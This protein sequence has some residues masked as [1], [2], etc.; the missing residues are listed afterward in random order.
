MQN[1]FKHGF[2]RTVAM[3]LVLLMLFTLLPVSA[4]AD[5]SETEPVIE[6]T[7]EAVS[8]QSEDAAPDVPESTAV[9]TVQEEEVVSEEAD[10]EADVP[11]ASEEAETDVQSVETEAADDPAP[12]DSEAA[13][14]EPAEDQ[15][16]TDLEEIEE[17][18]EIEIQPTSKKEAS[19]LWPNAEVF[20]YTLPGSRATVHI[21]RDSFLDVYFKQGY[22][23]GNFP[24][25]ATAYLTG[26]PLSPVGGQWAYCIDYATPAVAGN[27]NSVS[28]EDVALWK[29]K[30]AA[31]KL[32]VLL[33]VS[34]GADTNGGYLDW[35]ATQVVVWEYMAGRTS[36]S[37]NYSMG[38]SFYSDGNYSNP[39][40]DIL[41]KRTALLNK[42]KQHE[43]NIKL[44]GATTSGTTQTVTLSFNGVGNNYAQEIT[45]Q[46][47]VVGNGDWKLDVPEGVHAEISNGKIIVYPTAVFTGEKTITV[48][49]KVSGNAYAFAANQWLITGHPKNP[50]EFKIK[51]TVNPGKSFTLIKKSADLSAAMQACI[52]GNPLYTMKGAQYGVYTDSACNNLV[53]TLTTDANGKVT[54][55]KVWPVGT[56][57]YVK[58]I[59]APSGYLLDPQIHTL[60]IKDGENKLEVRDQPTFDPARIQIL[61]TGTTG[62]PIK[63][64]VFEVKFY[65]QN[66]VDENR[67]L[68]TWYFKSDENGVVS[69][70]ETNLMSEYNGVQSDALYKPNGTDEW[71]PLGCVVVKEVKAADGYILPTG[72]DGQIFLFVRQGGQKEPVNGAEAI[73]YWGTGSADPITEGN[74]YGIFRFEHGELT[75][76]NGEDMS[77]G[78]NA[79]NP[80]NDSHVCA[81]V[82]NAV[83]VDTVDYHNLVIGETYQVKGWLVDPE[84]GDPLLINGEK[85]TAE[86]EPFVAETRDGSIEVTFTFDASG[87]EGSS[88]V[89]FEE[90]WCN[91]EVI[92]DHKNKD[93]ENQTIE[94]PE[95]IIHT[96]AVNA[97]NGGKVF[98]PLDDVVLNDTVDYEGLVPGYEYILNGRLVFK[99]SG[100]SV[101]A[102]DGNP[103]VATVTFTP[104]ESNGSI[105]VPFTF[106]ASTLAGK[107]LVV[108]E[109]LMIGEKFVVKHEDLYDEGQTVRVTDGKLQTTALCNGAHEAVVMEDTVVIID[110]VKYEDLIPSTEYRLDGVLMDKDTA[111]P[112]RIHGQE[113]RSSVTFVAEEANGTVEVRFEFDNSGIVGKTVVVFETAYRNDKAFLV[114][115]DLGDE[116]QTVYFP[117]PEIHTTATNAEDGS[118][119][120]DPLDHVTLNDAVTYTNLA[121]NYSYTLN[122]SLVFKDSGDPVLDENGDPI[123]ATMTFKP[124]ESNGVVNVP[125][126]FDASSLNDREIVVFETLTADDSKSDAFPLVHNDLNDE[127]QTVRVTNPEI[128]TE[129]DCENYDNILIPN[130]EITINDTVNYTDLIP[131]KTYVIT[132][133]LMDKATEKPFL[134]NGEEAT[135]QT[136]FTPEEANG[137]VVVTFV[138]YNVDL[139]GT[140]LVAF[141]TLSRDDQE[142]AVHAD[143]N[144]E[145]QTVEF[146]E[147]SIHTMAVNAEDGSKVFDPLENAKLDDTV[148]YEGLLVGHTYGLYGIL[149]DKATGEPLLI[150]G[151]PVTSF[152]SF[153]AEES[154]G[155]IV[156]PFEFSAADL[157]GKELVVFETLTLL[158]NDDSVPLASHADL[159]DEGQTVKVNSPELGTMASSMSGEK[160]V[161]ITKAITIK[162]VVS[163][164]NLT[165]GKT[166]TVK[167]VLMDKSTG[168]PLLINGKEVTAEATFTPTE[169]DGTVVVTFTFNGVGLDKK[170]IVVFETLYREGQELAAHADINDENQT[171]TLTP[172]PRQTPPSPNTSDNTNIGIWIALGILAIGGIVIAVL[173]LTKKKDGE[174]ES[175]E[176]ETDTNDI[177]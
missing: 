46:N 38:F 123:T 56:T 39:R 32:G 84:T 58:E 54:T 133:V 131:G 118:K 177:E 29:N 116:M 114:H 166:Y 6:A 143:I 155:S 73:G 23:S 129:A 80:V 22:K 70:N 159:K 96:T 30:S 41:N 4:F 148:F 163:Y 168:K 19:E 37:Q 156:V 171:V 31:Q 27:Y 136:E 60:K 175:S 121:P 76:V 18:A 141:E 112:L 140:T 98:D 120:F 95:P 126:E 160:T 10:D 147:I 3:I 152:V 102:D 111:L 117:V 34:N 55:T 100:E 59:K 47:G 53:E 11:P 79:K 66:W 92:A 77:I 125:F 108:F 68:R 82:E 119:V 9:E 161:E 139:M 71:F 65:G 145:A 173:Y 12:I 97:E 154:T 63:D 48:D 137:S 158:D 13:N 15:I 128:E 135:A 49:R 21:Y 83:I 110:T 86:S 99:D 107:E 162:D 142:L 72:Y 165:P 40:S 90:L 134:I 157:A 150:N 61:K 94:F 20:V 85:V 122:G 8:E 104:E 153:V 26:N 42:I 62:T 33:A 103:V 17:Q 138:F 75:A 74:P 105:V 1:V 130:A 164:K 109:S 28:L 57:L 78:T 176:A 14:A 149:M 174:P 101:L 51:L 93:D 169:P 146:P 35:I 91:G 52:E 67:L 25:T 43:T 172:P 16:P 127:D 24:W 89:V 7:I 144:D 36:A 64:V 167:G 132:G 2:R 5:D 69:F 87:L 170:E 113:V 124:E 151:E 50:Y 81:A 88:T 106:N 115:A 44:A 45:D